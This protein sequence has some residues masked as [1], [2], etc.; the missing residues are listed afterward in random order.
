MQIVPAGKGEE[1]M[2]RGQERSPASECLE[3][4]PGFPA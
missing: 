4:I 2:V 1:D 3:T